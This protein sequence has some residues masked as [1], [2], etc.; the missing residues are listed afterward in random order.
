VPR[1]LKPRVVVIAGPNGAGKTTHAEALLETLGVNTFVNA[2]HVARGL[3]G[4]H[5]E[6]VA[7]DAGRIMLRRLRQLAD[8]KASFAFESTLSS[9]SFGLF[10]QRL[11]AAGYEIVILYFSLTSADLAV[12]RVRQRVRLGGHDVP[13]E[14]IKRRFFRSASNLLTIYLPLADGWV[15]FDNS[16]GKTPSIIAMHN[17]LK[18]DVKEPGKWQ[19]LE[20]YAAPR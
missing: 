6:D 17:G 11:K 20:K 5:A 12:R 1:K 19:R 2:D 15:A 16:S 10:L 18:L 14:V 4:R 3:S 8:E 7:I 9:R 13:A